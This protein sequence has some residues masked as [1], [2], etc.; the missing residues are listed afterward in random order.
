MIKPGLPLML[1]FLMPIGNTLN[2]RVT[3]GTDIRINGNDMVGAAFEGN[4]GFMISDLLMANAKYYRPLETL[5]TG[6]TEFNMSAY[7]FELKYGFGRGWT[8]YSFSRK[9]NAKDQ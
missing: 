5:H 4:L 9:R 6:K 8:K 2:I 1:N 7:L 3:T